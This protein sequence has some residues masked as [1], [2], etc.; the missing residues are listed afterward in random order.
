MRR[1]RGPVRRGANP[2]A[3]AVDDNGAHRASVVRL[4][5]RLPRRRR[6]TTAR[7]VPAV[8]DR[9]V[10]RA[11]GSCVYRSASEIAEAEEVTRLLWLAPN[12]QEAYRP[13][14]ADRG[15]PLNY[16]DSSPVGSGMRSSASTGSRAIGPYLRAVHPNSSFEEAPQSA[17]GERATP[18]PQEGSDDPVYGPY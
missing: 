2:G 12:I 14:P 7:G 13:P 8:R 1:L 16:Q 3:V 15:I 6:D 5:S 11:V 9:L 18:G 17:S 10:Q 4:R